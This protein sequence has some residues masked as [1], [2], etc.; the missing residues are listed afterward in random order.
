M[1][2]QVRRRRRSTSGFVVGW[3][4]ISTSIRFSKMQPLPS[5]ESDAR[6][7]LDAALKELNQAVNRYVSIFKTVD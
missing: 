1:T 6:A 5:R 7:E 4:V 3:K 2:E